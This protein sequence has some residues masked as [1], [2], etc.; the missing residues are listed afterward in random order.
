MNADTLTPDV[1]QALMQHRDYQTMQRHINMAR[2]L[3]PA[4]Q[5]LVVPPIEQ[6]GIG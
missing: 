6:R 3:K 4:V 5:N 2:Q 1:L